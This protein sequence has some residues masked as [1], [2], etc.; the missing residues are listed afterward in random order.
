M[1]S[2]AP[3]YYYLLHQ[4]SKSYELPHLSGLETTVYII[5]LFFHYSLVLV[6]KYSQIIYRIL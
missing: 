6:L 4:I 1:D 5:L 2:E 3:F